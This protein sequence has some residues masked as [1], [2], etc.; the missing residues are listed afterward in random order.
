MGQN[1]TVYTGQLIKAHQ[2]F[3]CSLSHFLSASK[4]NKRLNNILY[5]STLFTEGNKVSLW[6]KVEPGLKSFFWMD[7]FSGS[8]LKSCKRPGKL[9]GE[10]AGLP[11]ATSRWRIPLSICFTSKFSKTVSQREKKMVI[12]KDLSAVCPFATFPAMCWNNHR[13]EQQ[14]T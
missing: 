4:D 9:F 12:S 8:I 7:R 6:N 14:F 2:Y 10:N 1:W 13:E 11:W 3:Q 5:L